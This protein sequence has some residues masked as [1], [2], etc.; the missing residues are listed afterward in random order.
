MWLKIKT[1]LM[2]ATCALLATS[3]VAFADDDKLQVSMLLAGQID[4]KGFMEAG[5]NGLIAIRDQL[6]AEI[7]YIDGVAPKPD[8]LA[9]ALRELAAKGPDMVI[10]H[11]GQNNAAAE[12]VAAEFPDVKFVVVQGGVTGPNLSSYEVLQEESAWLAGAMAGL[13][14]ETGVVGHISGI[15]VTPGLKGRAG[16]YDGLMHTNPEAKFLTIFAGDQD[17][18]ELS[19]RVAS[20]EIEQGAD[21][22]FTMLNAGRT[23][24]IDAMRENGVKQIGNVRDWYPDHPD[25]FVASAIAN[26]SI[27][28][29][30]AAKDFKDGTWKPGVIVKIGLEDPNAAALAMS[31]DVPDDVRSRIDE[32]RQKIISDEIEVSVEYD[33]P[34]LHP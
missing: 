8:L 15:R 18:N 25:V 12:T 28:G 22:I 30:Q 16:F 10:A 5:Y 7:D 13:M 1:R 32:L 3:G 21:I 26:V 6:G 23:G 33:G 27:A 11:G 17:D 4:D 29:L 19:H 31:P 9:D 20:E 14:T 2:F 34:E 24:A